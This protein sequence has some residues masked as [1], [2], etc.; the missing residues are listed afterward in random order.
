MKYFKWNN[1]RLL[2]MLALMIFLYSFTSE[3]N[4]NRT[5]R[6]SEVIFA[7][8]SDRFV[9]VKTVNKLLIENKTTVAG[10]RKVTLDL[11]KLEKT[12]NNHG[13]IEKSE[14]F[15]TV[16][17]VLK[18]VV[19]QKTP[20]VRVLNGDGSYYIDY[21]GNK[22]PLSEVQS[23]RLPLVSGA[24]NIINS[25]A[26]IGFF[27]IIHDDDFLKKNIIGVLVLPNGNIKM[28]NRNFDYEIDFGKPLNIDGKFKN[29]KAFFQKA[30]LDSTL[31]N[32]KM[33]NLK[34]S[35]QVVCTK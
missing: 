11:N 17:G 31:Y 18:A 32:Y 14:V 34:F 23:A 16:D 20:I 35:Q 2:L 9:E 5:L 21:E 22:M 24:Q 13:M 33:V 28:K 6:K 10:I 7:G 15:V 12:L 19:K 4:A 25:E 1:V 8:G 27:R 3:R 29:Y 26:L 30:S